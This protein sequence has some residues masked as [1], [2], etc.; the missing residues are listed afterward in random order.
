MYHTIK[1]SQVDLGS[2]VRNA[3]HFAERDQV[4][5]DLAEALDRLEAALQGDDLDEIDATHFEVERLFAACEE[6]A[7]TDRSPSLSQWQ[8]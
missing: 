2:A 5:D 6:P 7:D 8:R 3:V 1:T 4:N